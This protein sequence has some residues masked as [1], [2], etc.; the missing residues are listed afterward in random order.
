MAASPAT[1]VQSAAS[2]ASCQHSIASYSPCQ[3]CGLPFCQEC[4]APSKRLEKL[5]A[6]QGDA[7]QNLSAVGLCRPC[8]ALLE[9]VV[10]LLVP[11]AGSPPDASKA[12]VALSML[13]AMKN[14]NGDGAKIRSVGKTMAAAVVGAPIAAV[15]AV[16]GVLGGV[17]G[18]SI[19]GAAAG[20]I[21]GAAAGLDA[22]NSVSAGVDSTHKALSDAA[23]A[24]PSLMQRLTDKVGSLKGAA[25]SRA[26]ATALPAAASASSGAGGGAATTDS[27]ASTNDSCGGLTS[28]TGALVMLPSSNNNDEALLNDG[29]GGNSSASSA[30]LSI[31]PSYPTG[32]NIG[33]KERAA[34]KEVVK[35]T[36]STGEAAAAS[37]GAAE[38]A[39]AGGAASSPTAITTTPSADASNNA[40]AA[41]PEVEAKRI[42]GCKNAYEILEVPTTA[43]DDEIRAA[44]KKK[45]RLYH[46]DR[47]ASLPEEQKKFAVACFQAVNNANAILSDPSKR[48]AYDTSKFEDTSGIDLFSGITVTRDGVAISTGL[49]VVAGIAGFGVGAVAGA[50]E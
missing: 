6:K 13:I 41:S 24:T 25:S 28:E 43:S 36:T 12:A 8:V 2:T 45:S 27:A 30:N 37:S 47:N 32:V 34:P 46:P 3:R 35:S 22:R 9:K 21:Y 44:Y 49:G 19:A 14:V 20:G 40:A 18:G 33:M 7:A 29:T 26:S 16:F 1:A 48:K 23:K 17:V 4:P 39:S 42:A 5:L 38:T 50:G 10:S 11:P 15:S 31:D